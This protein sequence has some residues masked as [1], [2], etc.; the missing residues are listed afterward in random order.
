MKRIFPSAAVLALMAVSLPAAAFAQSAPAAPMTA[1]TPS[2]MS[3][4]M[5]APSATPMAAPMSTPMSTPAPALSKAEDAKL[6]AHIK[7]LRQELKITTAEEPQW[8]AFA[9]VMRTNDA[10]MHQAFEARAKV[11]TMT[12]EQNMESYANIAEMHADG[13]QKL[14]AAFTT[15]Y[16]SFPDSQK[17]IADEVF[18]KQAKMHGNKR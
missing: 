12:A 5:S 18:Q 9:S 3:S 15:L 10:D 6:E 14:S 7:T 2:P 4:P 11:T 1:P 16:D 13:M 8:D 17:K